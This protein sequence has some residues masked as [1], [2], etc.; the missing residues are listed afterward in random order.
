MR[1]VNQSRLNRLLK[2]VA[3]AIGDPMG[4]SAA[5]HGMRRGYACDLALAGASLQKILGDV[6]WRSEAL[7]AYIASIKDHL[8]NR[9]L[10]G[11]LGDNSEDERVWKK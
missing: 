2:D 3:V 9:A 1:S 6:D 10:V 11:I 7:R 4:L 5:A 8:H